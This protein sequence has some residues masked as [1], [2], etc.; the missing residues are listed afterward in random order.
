M[1]VEI[2]GAVVSL[3]RCLCG[4]SFSSE[5]ISKQC[6]HMRKPEIVVQIFEDKIK[7]LTAREADLRIKLR[8]EKIRWGKD[9]TAEVNLWLDNF[10]KMKDVQASLEEKINGEKSRLCR[11]FPNYY[12]RLKL[13]N[14]VTKKMDE[15]DKLIEQSNFFGSSLV[16]MLPGR[17][18]ILP[19][20]HALVGEM[21]KTISLRI[22]KYIIDT[23]ILII[24][25]YGMGG[26][27]KTTLIKEI[28]NKLLKENTHFDDVIWVTA[29]KDSNVQKLQKDIAKEIGLP[30]D[31]EDSELT[32][33][34]V[35]F[36]ALLRRGRFFLIIDD[37]WEAFSLEDIGIPTPT[38][39]NGCKLLI[40]TRLSSVC[41]GMETTKEIEVRVL[42]EK[43]AWDLFKQKVGEE[44]LSSKIVCDLAKEIAKECGGLPLA[45]ITVG[46][47]VRKENNIK[48][49][50]IALSELR[51]STENIEGMQNKVFARLRFSYDRLKNDTTRACFRYCALY[52]EDHLIETNE[53]IKYW[54]WEGLLSGNG[55]HI[56][57][58]QMGDMILNELKNACLLESV[59]QDGS[60]NEY[61]KMH[62]LIR[63]MVIAFT[64]ANST[65]MVKSGQ[66]LRDPPGVTEWTPD[67]E[68]VSLMRNDL[69]GLCYEPRCPKL[70]T[71]LVQYNSI[72]KGISP[73]F[74]EHI[75]NLKLLDLSY[76]GI[77]KLPDLVSN[78]ESLHTLL[79]R[80]CWNLSYVPT[81]EKLVEL[82][83]LDFSFTSINCMPDGMEM[84]VNLQYLDLSFT[85]LR[86]PLFEL[87]DYM[88]LECLFIIGTSQ[89]HCESLPVFNLEK[90]R[91]LVALQVNFRHMKDFNHYIKSGHWRL[92][93]N[94]S[95]LIGHP[96]PSMHTGKNY[97]GFFGVDFSETISKYGFPERTLELEICY[98]PSIK[99]LPFLSSRLQ[100]LK[101]K[102]CD[103]ME[104]IATEHN[105]F[106]N[107]EW[108][109]IESLKNLSL[110]YR[111]FLRADA[112]PRLKI[113][114]V[115]SCNNLKNLLS[116]EM[117]QCLKSLVEIII[118]E[119]EK[120]E[121]VISTGEITQMN[122]PDVILPNLRTVKLS[123][124]PKLKHISGGVMTCDSL[125]S[126]EVFKCPD[127]KTISFFVQ[128]REDLIN[129]VEQIKGSTEWWNTIRR[130]HGK[131]ADLLDH[132][133]TNIP[134]LFAMEDD[135]IL[136]YD[137][138]SS[139][140]GPR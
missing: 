124:L 59:Y 25:V 73:T 134:K 69:S 115:K 126:L 70:C 37:L 79:L 14:Y 112:F 97:I 16:N 118:E 66:G 85:N 93:K 11:C 86:N 55:N 76:T 135:S 101:I 74:F 78:L 136:N 3:A 9:P 31:D 34:S 6:S 103:E 113:L 24:G 39:I 21:A 20:G 84:L 132:V 122:H 117:A 105:I 133:F 127:L 44:V 104:C 87:P 58:T 57:K 10:Q 13:G 35:L 114:H 108:L 96:I 128:I 8:Q 51:N 23:D 22:W 19:T 60:S 42:S 107:L 91:N 63:D 82:R 80:S 119:C 49:W 75:Q 77:D 61:V 12:H 7:I 53:L 95:F 2:I 89:F 40:T 36:N 121:E 47:A 68:R 18:K 138:R 28:N 129:S 116:F 88:F 33:A 48:S 102:F 56:V 83:V 139:S 45:L 123:C 5:L 62:D 43:E 90:C 46:L 98:C 94:F 1:S 32:R 120:I 4:G 81:L 92:L 41:R 109:E 27:G 100:R 26:V 137:S 130:N 99:Y 50:D 131:A 15:V 72:S 29:S 110:L 54:V 67:L 71:L 65:F 106:P 125:S 140:F 111:R 52:P 17:G 64:R 38:N 30:L